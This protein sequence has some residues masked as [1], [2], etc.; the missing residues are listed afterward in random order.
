MPNGV[1]V[2]PKDEKE[3]GDM[4]WDACFNHL[5]HR[6]AWLNIKINFI[7]VFMAIELGLTGFAITLLLEHIGK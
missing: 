2:R 3:Q 6:L 4:I 7:L 1:V 5:P